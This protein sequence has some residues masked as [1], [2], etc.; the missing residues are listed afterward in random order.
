[1]RVLH[2]SK[3]TRSGIGSLNRPLQIPLR[4]ILLLHGG[5]GLGSDYLEPLETLAEQGRTVIRFDQLGSGRSDRPRDLSLWTISSFVEQTESIRKALGHDRIHLLGHSW[6]GMVAL[7]YILK[8]PLRVQSAC[9]CSPVISFKLWV[10]ETRRLH[11][12]MPSY[13]VNALDRLA[14]SFCPPKLPG[15]GAKPARSLTQLQIDLK[16]IMLALFFLLGSLPLVASIASWRFWTRI[17]ILKQFAYQILNIQ[18]YRRYGCRLPHMPFNIFRMLA[19]AN[20]EINAYLMGPSALFCSGVLKDWDIRPRLPEICCPTLIL[21]GRYDQATPMQMAIL[22]KGIR[23]GIKE[24]IKKGVNQR[25]SDCK[26]IVLK[27]SAHCG[28][29]E[30]P[31][32]FRTAIL[33]FVNR[34]EGIKMNRGYMGKILWVD[35]SQG[36]CEEEVLPEEVYER[37][38][39]GMGLAAYILYKNIPPKTDPLGPDNILGFVPGLLTGTGSLFTGRWMAVGKSPLTGTW[40]EANC[41][42][43]FSPAIKQCG[44][45]GIFFKGRSERPVYLYADHRK[46]ELRNA[47]GLWGKDTF[48]TVEILTKNANGKKPCVAC[49]GPAGEKLSLISGI[50][51]DKGRMA[52]RSGLGAVMGSKNL[53]A[54]VL[55]GSRRVIPYDRKKMHTLSKECN[56]SIERWTPFWWRWKHLVKL[57]RRVPF[58]R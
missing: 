37:F 17:S 55:A 25:I 5:P 12:Q 14:K 36:Q 15:P 16:A 45:D 13:I 53:K 58:F 46:V 33:D 42:G 4:P 43:T 49:I 54:V 39:S 35:L 3:V 18:F 2:I 7:E 31:D 41:G 30:E 29:W 22:K 21:S 56:L 27:H 38:L 11:S 40:G 51:N 50:S 34:S 8:Y 10:K 9:L 32:K 47:S 1:M 48:E 19:G 23:Q 57:L 24:R 52:A 44:Y 28:M 20:E 6:G 26:Q